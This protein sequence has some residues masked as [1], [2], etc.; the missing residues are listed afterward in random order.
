MLSVADIVKKSQPSVFWCMRSMPKAQREAMY[1][2]FAFCRHIF[3][4]IRSPMSAAE[5]KELL[6]AWREELDN[7]YDRNVPT[8]NIGRKIYKNCMRF[9]LPKDM[10]AEI[11]NSASMEAAEPLVAPSAAEFDRYVYG[12]AVVPVYLSMLIAGET[13]QETVRKFSENLGRAVMITY[14]LRDIKDDAKCGH[15]YIP[16]EIVR[17]AGIVKASPLSMA[18]NKN[19]TAARAELAGQAGT[20][21]KKVFRLLGKM[22]NKSLVPLKFIAGISYSYFRQMDKRGWEIIYPK[23]VISLP[24]KLKMFFKLLFS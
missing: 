2:L 7:I 23:P 24:E 16:E 13:K 14:M 12:S 19:L 10:L 5:K 11:L 15:F 6:G 21:Y 17:N 18:E 8:T 22:N 20:S 9:N 4:I 3:N 1:T